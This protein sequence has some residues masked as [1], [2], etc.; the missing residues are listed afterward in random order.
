MRE[1]RTRFLLS[2]DT[3]RGIDPDWYHLFEPTVELEIRG[4]QVL[5]EHLDGGLRNVIIFVFMEHALKSTQRML[6]NLKSDDNKEFVYWFTGTGHGLKLCFHD[7]TFEVELVTDPALGP[8]SNDALIR[9]PRHLGTV[10][11]VEWVR[12][13]VGLGQE[14]IS[15]F[16]SYPDSST[17]LKNQERRILTLQSWL[18]SRH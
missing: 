18:S 10:D 14:L 5:G 1:P 12:A 6:T 11:P 8:V 17:V 13:I 7:K 4:K 16:K 15:R 9:N 2:N 3:E